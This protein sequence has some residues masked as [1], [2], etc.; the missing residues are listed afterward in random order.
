MELL[1]GIVSGLVTGVITCWF[2]YWLAGKDLRRE[3]SDLRQLNILTIR[4][5]AHAG[6]AEFNFDAQGKPIGLIYRFEAEGKLNLRGEALA[7][8]HHPEAPKQ[9][10]PSG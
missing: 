7:E 6:L 2:F 4:A 1:G 8:V 10:P 5:L 9:S 3:A